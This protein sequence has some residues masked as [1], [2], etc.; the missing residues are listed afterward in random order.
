MY[1]ENMCVCVCTNAYVAL[2]RPFTALSHIVFYEMLIA[3]HSTKF[4]LVC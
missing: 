3:N 1:L 4:V 2:R